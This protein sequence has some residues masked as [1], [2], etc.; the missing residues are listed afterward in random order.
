M[1]LSIFLS[2]L[3]LPH[4][5]CGMEAKSAGFFDNFLPGDTVA[6]RVYGAPGSVHASAPHRGELPPGARR[7]GLRYSQLAYCRSEVICLHA[8]LLALILVPIGREHGKE[9]A[10]AMAL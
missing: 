5:N 1:M 4:P 10:A 6:R 3:T 8:L 2:P 9:S 7:A